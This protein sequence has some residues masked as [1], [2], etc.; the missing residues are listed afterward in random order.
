MA[1]GAPSAAMGAAAADSTP[2]IREMYQRLA[3]A[4]QRKD[5]RGMTKYI[6]GNWQ[7]AGG[8]SVAD[9]ESALSSSFRTFDTIQFQVQGL[10][11]Q[12]SGAVEY[13]VTYQTSLTAKIGKTNQQRQ[14]K[15]AI[16]DTVVVGADGPK[17]TRTAGG[18][19]AVK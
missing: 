8:S 2:Q 15:S 5:L 18:S 4:Y 13:R 3:E 12:K 11:I 19:L 14:E 10:Q 1:P 9:L 16:T 7:G 17:I 6:A